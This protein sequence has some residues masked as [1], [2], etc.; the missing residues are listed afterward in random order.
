M[1]TSVTKVFVYGTLRRGNG[2]YRLLDGNTVAEY[3]AVLPGARLYA[4]GIPWVTDCPDGSQVIGELMVLRA[5][6]ADVVLQRLDRLEGYRP[7]RGGNMYERVPRPVLFDDDGRLRRTMAWVYFAG[8][9]V[10]SRLTDRD[11][12]PGGDWLSYA[13]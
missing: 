13:S 6:V 2:N 7:G 5:D 8:H 3:P 12:V 4:S 9:A 11:R 1:R 10:A